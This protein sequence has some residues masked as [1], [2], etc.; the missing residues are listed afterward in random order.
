MYRTTIPE[1]V[2]WIIHNLVTELRR[3]F[4]LNSNVITIQIFSLVIE[5]E[6]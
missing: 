1:D 5:L 2:L 4:N 6:I 3:A